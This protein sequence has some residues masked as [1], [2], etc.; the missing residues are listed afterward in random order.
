MCEKS[1]AD[2]FMSI[3]KFYKDGFA[4]VI[5]LRSTQD[6]TTGGGKKIMNTQSGVLLEITKKATTAD[7]QCNIF[8]VSDAL[9]NFANRDLSSI[10]Y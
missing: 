9:P 10:Q 3:D 7:V 5:D 4:L 2:E 6:D 8:V 1:M